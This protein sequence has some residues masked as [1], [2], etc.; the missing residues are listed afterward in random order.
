LFGFSNIIMKLI[1]FVSLCTKLRKAQ[2]ISGGGENDLFVI[3]LSCKLTGLAETLTLK[4][5]REK[6][7]RQSQLSVKVGLK[8]ICVREYAS[9]IRLI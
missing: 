8:S 7:T 4:G 5:G 6:V 1:I 3:N 9:E 2:T